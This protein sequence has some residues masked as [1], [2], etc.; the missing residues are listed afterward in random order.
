VL[1]DANGCVQSEE[2][3]LIAPDTIEVNL[4]A[5][6]YPNGFNISCFGAGDG[7]IEATATGGTPGYI[8]TWTGSGGFGPTTDNPI[9]DLEPGEYNINVE[10]QN[11]CSIDETITLISPDTLGISLNSPLINGN[12]ISCN[13]GNDGSIDLSITGNAAPFEISWTLDGNPLPTTDQDLFNLEAGEYCVTVTDANDC[14]QSACIILTEPDPILVDLEAFIYPNGQNVNCPDS[15][16]GFIVTAVSGGT[17]PYT[18]FWIGPDNYT[19]TDFDIVGLF[20]GTYC[21][22]V[23]DANGCSQEECITLVGPDPVEI[24]ADSNVPASCNGANDASLDITVLGG[25]PDF[26]F[27]WT[28]PNGFT[29]N[30]QNISNLEPGI[31]CVSLV[32]ANNC[33]A[34]ECFTVTEPEALSAT[35]SAGEFQGGFNIDCAGNA[36]GSAIVNPAGGTAPYTFS[37]TGPDGFTANGQSISGLSAGEYCVEVVDANGCN[38]SDCIDLIEPAPLE[39]NPIVDLPD[40]ADGTLATIDLNVSG[41]TPGYSFNWNTPDNTEVIQVG[42]GSYSVII[43]DANGCF[44]EEEFNIVLPSGITLIAESPNFNGFNIDCNGANTGSINLSVFDANGIFTV[45]WTGPDGFVSNDQNLSG[46]VAGTYCAELIDELGCTAN[47]CIELTQPNPISVTFTTSPISCDAGIDGGISIEVN[48]GVPTYMVTWTGPNGFTGTGTEISGLEAGNYCAEIT[49]FNG[50]VTVDCID[51]LAPAPLDIELTSPEIGGVNILCFGDNSGEI[52]STISGGTPPYSFSWVG[53][54]GFLSS[55]EELMNLFVGEYCLTVTDAAGCEL[56]ECITLTESDGIEFTFDVFE[57]PNGFNTS[58]GGT[59]DGS[60]EASFVGGT[61][62][63][64]IVWTGPPG[65]SADELE[66]T[67]LCAGTYTLNTTDANGCE[68]SASV[69]LLQPQPI[70]IDLE[71]EVFGGGNEI[72]CFGENTGTIINT[73]TGGIGELTFSWSGP[74]GFTSDEQ[75]LEELFAGTYTVIV[76]DE[77]GCSETASIELTEPEAP[78]SATGIPFT[79]PSGTNISCLDEFDGSIDVVAQGGTEPYSFNWNGPNDYTSNEQNPS[80]LEAGEYT[81]VVEDANSCVFTINFTLTEPLEELS[82]SSSIT[83]ELLC[84]G[85]ETGTILVAA[86]GGSPEYSI[87]WTGPDGF[88]ANTLKITNLGA[89]TYNYVLTDLNGCTS[90]GSE[91]LT[92]PAPLDI[93]GEVFE[94]ECETPTG[95]INITVTGGTAPY[96]YSWSNGDDSQDLIDILQGEYT[97]TVTDGNACVQTAEFTVTSFNSLEA[98]PVAQEPSCNGDNDGS[99][100]LEITSGTDPIS[101]LWTGPDG[102]ESN[103]PFIDNLSSGTYTVQL[104]DANGCTF[105]TEIT[106]DEPEPLTLEPLD[107]FFY[108]NGFNLSGFESQDGVINAPEV[109]GGTQPYSYSWTSDNGY[110]SDS[111]DNQLNLE[112]GTYFVTVTDANLC[113]IADSIILT[114][115]IPIEIPNGISPNGDGFNDGFTVRGIESFPSNKLLVFNR[116]GNQVYEEVNFSNS[117]PWLGT[118]EGGEEL[119]EGTYFVVVELEGRDALTGYL[120]IRR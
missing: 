77:T 36:T 42:E 43:T 26:T 53:P 14:S 88:T 6:L 90:T 24:I 83:G 37:W 2:I 73:V 85:D 114:Q 70:V 50:C 20:A 74:D 120:E 67:D 59:C 51:L 40:C 56:Q 103:E 7:S 89:G 34:E 29:S 108:A 18:A 91:V 118:R 105:S 117:D 82:S 9:T 119:P 66:I 68:Q 13:G 25:D 69:T 63:V 28:G 39:A 102:F 22:T 54:N 38:F 33:A 46:L 106:L 64:E 45:T 111:G 55:Q 49:D 5:S 113:S 61:D 98:T 62:P 71:S 41:G 35:L 17:M 72:S 79:Y 1:F 10:D 80:N 84:N 58:C 87:E 16:D 23:T 47:T 75:D 30:S 31:Y 95:S 65:F 97:L 99:I 116:W 93:T 101:Y 104:E 8:F 3:E 86:Q 44:V 48:G 60:I 52:N 32:D 78:L 76:T 115:P 15:Q 81:L 57:Y 109:S 27:T 11:G 12:N 94:A 4:D 110:T 96:T 19:S 21:L 92:A 100:A 107:A 112:A